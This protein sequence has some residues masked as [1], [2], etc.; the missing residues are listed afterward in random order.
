MKPRTPDS[1]L[2][3]FIA[4][5]NT[6]IGPRPVSYLGTFRML[7]KGGGSVLEFGENVTLSMARIQFTSGGGTIR[8]GRDVTAKGRLEVTGG[9]EVR[10]DEGTFLNR[11]CDIRGGEG[12]TVHI[13]KNCLFSNVKVMTSDM[14][15]ILDLATGK[16]TNSAASIVIEDEVWIAED[17]KIAKGVRVGTGAVIAA[18]SLVTRSIAPLCLAAGRPARVIRTGV[19]WSRTLKRMQPQPAPDFQAADIPLDKEVLRLLVSRQEYAVVDGV[20]AR[21]M[22]APLPLFAKW[23]LV[24]CRDKLGTPLPN[25]VALLDEILAEAPGHDAARKMRAQLTR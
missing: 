15:S 25:A 22:D 11:A 24:L 5:G 6:V 4:D 19:S 20:I 9:G 7:W 21:H 14:H 12:A 8:L 1:F 18:G 17:V 10:I 16:R 23:Y 2:D 3:A 13:G